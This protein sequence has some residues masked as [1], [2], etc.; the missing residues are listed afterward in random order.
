MT[1]AHKRM[2]HKKDLIEKVEIDDDCNVKLLNAKGED[3]RDRDISAGEKQI[4]TQALISAVAEVSGRSFPM[5][6]D[7][8]LGRLDVDHRR[9]VLQHLTR[10]KNQ[11]ILL[12]TYTEVVGEYLEQL[13]PHLL[14]TM[15]IKHEQIDGI[16]S[17]TPANGYFEAGV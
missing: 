12:S 1:Q 11:V 9:G 4:F 7:T 15:L 2:S 8:P 13:E 14:K 6:I 10:A 3:I 17:S 5:L 16:G